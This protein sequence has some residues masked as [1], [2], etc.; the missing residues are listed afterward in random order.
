MA[1]SV[2]L[3]YISEYMYLYNIF[4]SWYMSAVEYILRI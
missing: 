2:Q 4:L 3:I 1:L